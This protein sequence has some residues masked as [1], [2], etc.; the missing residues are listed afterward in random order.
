[1][2]HFQFGSLHVFNTITQMDMDDLSNLTVN[3]KRSLSDLYIDVE[4]L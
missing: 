4:L 2:E 1:M 3:K